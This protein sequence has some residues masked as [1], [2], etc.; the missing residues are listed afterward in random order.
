MGE[1]RSGRDD[2]GNEEEVKGMGNEDEVEMMGE[3]RRGRGDGK[4]KK[5]SR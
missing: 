5:R 4:T 3:R 2:K 1:Q